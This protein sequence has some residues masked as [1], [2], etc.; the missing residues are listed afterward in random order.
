M[1]TRRPSS[2]SRSTTSPPGNHGGVRGPVSIS[3]SMSLPAL[4][5]PRAKE[6]NTRTRSTPCLAAIARIA[7]RLSLPNSS[8]VMHS[9][10]RTCGQP[11]PTLFPQEHAIEFAGD[12][13]GH[14]RE[15]ADGVAIDDGFG[16]G[17]QN[18]QAVES[19]QDIA[20]GDQ[21]TIVFE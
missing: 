11:C 19:L 20:A 16:G 18:L 8:R 6:P 3:K 9:H 15:G 7:A 4:A 1:S 21:H 17:F 10:S 14:G 5:S 13:L 12:G 2:S